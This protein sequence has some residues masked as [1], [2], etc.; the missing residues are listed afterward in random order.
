M[1]H[2]SYSFSININEK[3][4]NERKIL[5]VDDNKVKNGAILKKNDQNENK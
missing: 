3:M 2:D 4:I 1:I 5:N